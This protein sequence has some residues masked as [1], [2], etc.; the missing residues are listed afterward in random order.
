MQRGIELHDALRGAFTRT[1]STGVLESGAQVAQG[2]CS[3]RARK[4]LEL[5]GDGADLPDIVCV[6]GGSYQTAAGVTRPFVT[7]PGPVLVELTR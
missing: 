4:G 1:A 6:A 5:V 7:Q 2:H 3:D